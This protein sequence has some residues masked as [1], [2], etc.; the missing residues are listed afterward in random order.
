MLVPYL[1]TIDSTDTAAAIAATGCA[2]VRL[3]T[4]AA[5]NSTGRGTVT[6]TGIQVVVSSRGEAERAGQRTWIGI[7][8]TCAITAIRIK[9]NGQGRRA[10]SVGVDCVAIRTTI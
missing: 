8:Y 10:N 2:R 7:I 9:S 5:A 4:R 1:L 3:T 6:G